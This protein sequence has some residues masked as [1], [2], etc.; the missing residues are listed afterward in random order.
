MLSKLRG[1][2]NTKL[3]GVLITIIIIPFVFWGMGSVFSG[4]NTNNV[5]KINNEIISAQDFIDYINRSRLDLDLIKKNIDNNSIENILNEIISSK[6]LEMEIDNFKISVSEKA[7]AKRIRNDE[8]FF[9]DNKKFSRIKYEKFLLENNLTAP[10]LENRLLNQMLKN[11]LYSYIGGGI[12]SPNFLKNKIYVEETKE[13]KI[14]Y[15]NLDLVYDN[16]TSEEEIDQYIKDNKDNLMEE[17]VDFSYTKITPSNLI[18]IDSFND[19][20]FKKIDE[21]ENSILNGSNLDEIKKKHNLKIETI[22]NFKNN[23]DEDEILKEIYSERNNDKVQL[24]DKNDYYLL[25]EIFK[26]NKVLPNKLD[27]DFVQKVKNSIILKKKFEFNKD[28]F[29]KIREKKLNDNEFIK[30]LNDKGNIK[31]TIIKSISDNKIFSKDSVKLIYSLSKNNFVLITDMNNK[32]YLAKITDIYSQNLLNSDKNYKNYSIKSNKKI[33]DQIYS[34]Y[35]L[36]L[37]KKYKVKVFNK[38]LDRIKNNFN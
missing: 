23:K 26:I 10:D 24:I 1:F 31:N 4:G 19:D 27:N 5:A 2:S 21:I 28:L 11:N 34:S 33:I 3:A 14:E 18:E 17:F 37:N 20:F 9:G 38:T 15:F 6:L 7:L 25:F 8:V 35:D 36:S 13:V 30:I 16:K 22:I 32:V 29:R 12:K